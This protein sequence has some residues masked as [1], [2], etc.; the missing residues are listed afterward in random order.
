MGHA[1]TVTKE[2]MRRNDVFADVCNFFL[3]IETTAARVIKAVTRSDMKFDETKEEINMCK[4]IE[5]MKEEAYTKGKTTGV[6]EGK[7][8]ATDERNEFF[9]KSMIEKGYPIEAVADI[10]NWTVEEIKSLLDKMGQNNM[11]TANN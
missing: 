2:Y 8:E 3:K 7:K 10:L 6:V 5:D 9:V 1:D 11:I 4:A